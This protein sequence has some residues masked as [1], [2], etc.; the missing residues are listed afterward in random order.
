VNGSADHGLKDVSSSIERAPYFFGARLQIV[1]FD[2]LA[3]AFT[4]QEYQTVAGLRG[5][6]IRVRCGEPDVEHRWTYPQAEGRSQHRSA[7][8]IAKRKFPTAVCTF[9]W[10]GI[11]LS[12]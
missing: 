12:Y 5:C 2:H 10:H 11:L 9:V 6:R 7:L 1:D 3:F 4:E 8:G